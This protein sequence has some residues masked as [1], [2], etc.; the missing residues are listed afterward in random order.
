[1]LATDGFQRAVYEGLGVAIGRQ[2]EDTI[3]KSLLLETSFV[4]IGDVFASLVKFE[5]DVI[6]VG[7]NPE[8]VISNHAILRPFIIGDSIYSISP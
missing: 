8:M 3:R 6:S 7:I 5:R 2:G 4:V 1:M